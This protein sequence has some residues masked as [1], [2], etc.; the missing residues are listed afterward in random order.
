MAKKNVRDEPLKP[1]VSENEQMSDIVFILDK[2]ELILQA[3]SKIGKDGKYSTVPADKEHSNSFLKIDRYANMFE[4][5]VKN[6]WSQ[7]KDPTRFGILSVKADTLDSPE[8]KQAIED[9]AAGKQTKA[10]EDFL[11]KYEIV[12]RDKENQ[13][14]NNQNQEE[15][16]KK[17]QTQQQAAPETGQQP[18]Q[19]PQYRYNES[20][21]NWEELKNFGLSREYLMERGLLDQMLRGYKTNQVVPISMNFG[22]AVLRTDARLSFQQ[23]VGGPIVLGIHGIRQKPE[24]ERP[25]FGH[26]FS[27]E[28]KK[29]LLETGNMG[30][31]VELKGR[32]GEYI[33]SFISIDKLTNEVVAMRAENAYIPQEIKGVKLTDQEINDLR[34]GKKVFI[35]GMISNNG[36]EFDA[37]IQ[38]NAER[39]GI[40]Y[41]FENDKL[42]NRQSLGGVELTKQQIEDLNAG[43]AIFV[44]GMERK[45]GELFSSYVKL[46]EATGRPS[47]TRYNPDSPEGAREIYIPNEIGGVKITAEEQQQLRE[48]KVIFLNDMVNRK[49]EEFSSFIKADL[50]TGR[51]SYSRTP[52]GFEQ[53]AEFKIPEKVWDVKLT[54]NQRA[55]LQS[56]KAVLVEGIKGYDGKTISQYV[57]ANFNQGRL[58]FYNENPDRKRDA[59]Q[60]NVVANAQKQGQEQAGRKSKGASIA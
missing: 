51:L 42:F 8:V 7:L 54:R 39:R 48:G 22:S 10:V 36:K 2:M 41:I 33:P 59:S 3:V 26:I 5:F 17:N 50:E 47:Y 4:N 11:K 37:H 28:D 55:D 32:N 40:E 56:G 30:R 60:R 52:D 20:M 25:Y 13:S 16:A 46:D 49:G 44:E 19:Q 34:E 29:N 6:F 53:R 43:K 18:Q 27:E 24:L 57:K 38:V 14:I 35:E 9:L 31:V 15:M 23:S 12:P 21:I 45:D 58:D 1:Q